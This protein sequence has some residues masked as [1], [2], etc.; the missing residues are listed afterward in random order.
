LFGRVVDVELL[1]EANVVESVE[2]ERN[3]FMTVAFGA[4]VQAI[5]A[6]RLLDGNRCI[7]GAY[8]IA[9]VRQDL[10]LELA[11]QRLFYETAQFVEVFC[12]GL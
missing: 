4:H 11:D 7:S 8:Q 5:V 9:W 2:N 1:V 6:E 3:N 12:F 10:L